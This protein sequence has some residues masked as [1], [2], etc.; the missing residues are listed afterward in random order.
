MSS[1]EP[2]V[3]PIEARWMQYR[4]LVVP[5]HASDV[6]VRCTREAFYA[7]AAGMYGAIVRDATELPDSDA[8]KALQQLGDELRAHAANPT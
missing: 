7:G 4:L 3:T 2:L 8:E 5:P 1:A 6:Q